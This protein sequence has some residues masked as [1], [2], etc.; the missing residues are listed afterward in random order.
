MTLP[1][2][3]FLN[4]ITIDTDRIIMAIPK[5][6]PHVAMR[7]AGGICS[8]PVFFPAREY[9]RLAINSSTL[10]R[11]AWDRLRAPFVRQPKP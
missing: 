5:A 8:E 4:P 9:I 6:T 2:I 11:R 3:S 7:M 10:I 1:L